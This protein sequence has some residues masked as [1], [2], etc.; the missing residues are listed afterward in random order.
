VAK[1]LGPR[2]GYNEHAHLDR[3]DG[4]WT[5]EIKLSVLT[6]RIRMGGKMRI[7]PNGDDKCR[8]IVDLWTDVKIFGLGGM[9]EK[10]AEK[11]LRDGWGKSATWLVE[12]FAKEAKAKA[13]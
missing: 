8:R 13:D 1:L 7:E 11:N 9:V 3:D 10:A 4:V 6:D 2:L 5:F 12:T